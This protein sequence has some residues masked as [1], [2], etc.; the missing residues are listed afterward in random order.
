MQ[1]LQT[2]AGMDC[3]HKPEDTGLAE[4][5]GPLQGQVPCILPG[6]CTKTLAHLYME[7]PL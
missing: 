4:E 3:R 1:N 6:C 2:S 5:A 7:N